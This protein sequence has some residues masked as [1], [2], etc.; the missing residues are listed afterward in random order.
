MQERTHAVHWTVDEDT[1][2]RLWRGL[3]T[4]ASREQ[5]V[6]SFASCDSRTSLSA[7]R[8]DMEAPRQISGPNPGRVR[9]RGVLVFRPRGLLWYENSDGVLYWEWETYPAGA[10][11]WP[12]RLKSLCFETPFN[13]PL[14]TAVFP[15]SLVEID[16]GMSFVHPVDRVKW[17]SLQRL[18]FSKYYN[19][20][21]PIHI[22]SR[23]ET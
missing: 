14:E 5:A 23:G 12:P 13:S 2:E 21:R 6:A 10:V 19:N 20:S 11:A 7:T 15:C 16:L 1:P 17:P 8:R 9:G 4:T 18:R 3:I 22:M